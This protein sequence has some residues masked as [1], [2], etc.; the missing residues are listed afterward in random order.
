MLVTVLSR[1][2]AVLL[3]LLSWLVL[4]LLGAVIPALAELE[5]LIGMILATL[6]VNFAY[7]AL[8]WNKV[9][10]TLTLVTVLIALLAFVANFGF[11]LHSFG[12]M[13][14][15]VQTWRGQAG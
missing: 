15:A 10:D 1:S 8:A 4:A 9:L 6:G 7:I 14:A 12:E 5:P 2:L 11:G 13:A 3:T